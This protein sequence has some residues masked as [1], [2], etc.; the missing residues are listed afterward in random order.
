MLF[1]VA[2]VSLNLLCS[3]ESKAARDDQMF[4]RALQE[5]DKVVRDAP[6]ADAIPARLLLIGFRGDEIGRLL[7]DGNLSE[8]L[9][10][11]EIYALD[12]TN[13]AGGVLQGA[14]IRLHTIRGAIPRE[15]ALPQYPF[16][17]NFFDTI[18]V[19]FSTL[20][21]FGVDKLAEFSAIYSKRKTEYNPM[22]G[23]FVRDLA[24]I[25]YEYKPVRG[26]EARHL[27]TRRQV[28]IVNGRSSIRVN[29]HERWTTEHYLTFIGEAGRNLGCFYRGRPLDADAVWDDVIPKNDPSPTITLVIRA[30]RQ[31][32]HELIADFALHGLTCFPV[33]TYPLRSA[34]GSNGD[35]KVRCRKL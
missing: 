9:R 14:D 32:M 21:F 19:D 7:P 13:D 4:E 1:V 26:I 18:I 23:V 17:A 5:V 35:V 8:E 16:S 12:P 25:E 15:G 34:F 20:K 31:S 10:Q 2:L 11:H 28:E 3:V 6:D 30:G 22:D 27:E 24:S 29:L 33:E